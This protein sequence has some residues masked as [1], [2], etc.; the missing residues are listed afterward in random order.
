MKP[1]HLALRSV[2]LAF[3]FLLGNQPPVLAGDTWSDPYPGIRYRLM[4]KIKSGKTFEIHALY[5]DSCH[6]A[7]RIKVSEE[8]DS[9]NFRVI[10]YAKKVG[11]TLA[12][13]GDY[14]P[15]F[16][17]TMSDGI[18]W[19]QLNTWQISYKPFLACTKEHMCE[20]HFDW[21]LSLP[22]D[23]AF[24]NIIG[25]AQV[26]VKD[27]VSQIECSGSPCNSLVARTAYGVSQDKKTLILVVVE[28][29]ESATPSPGMARDELADLMIELGAYSAINMD[30]SGS[31]VVI[32]KNPA[33]QKI[34]NL[35]NDPIGTRYPFNI[36]T[37][38]NDPSAPELTPDN[39]KYCLCHSCADGD[40][41]EEETDA[42][43]GGNPEA[44]NE[45]DAAVVS[46]GQEPMEGTE[47]NS[48]LNGS[49]GCG[50]A[51]QNGSEDTTGATESCLLLLVMIGFGS[52]IK[53]RS[54]IVFR[55]CDKT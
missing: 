8:K 28:G 22:L 12:I 31:S 55:R 34:E 10:E 51:F 52:Y 9:K 7:N 6:P 48:S 3:I 18:L 25:G 11:S 47:G 16:G 30:G 49:C 54:L 46:D 4:T 17:M 19:E 1:A 13:N 26:L 41:G 15:E 21:A 45:E 27:G 44:D 2:I 32:W 23:P 50:F 39:P 5:I 29:G 35:S 43:E 42:G 33:N 37:V 14:Y 40:G 36:L 20:M 53:R 24:Y 38:F